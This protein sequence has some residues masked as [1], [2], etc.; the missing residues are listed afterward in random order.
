MPRTIQ[1]PYVREGRE[2]TNEAISFRGS[3]F[4]N[5]TQKKDRGESAKIGLEKSEVDSFADENQSTHTMKIGGEGKIGPYSK[6]PRQGTNS[7]DLMRKQAPVTAF[8]E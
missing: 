3:E 1:E 7:L 2:Y 4:T 5:I 6:P 8:T